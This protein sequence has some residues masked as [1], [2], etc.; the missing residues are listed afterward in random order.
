MGKRVKSCQSVII[1]FESLRNSF[2]Y[3]VLSLLFSYGHVFHC[4][5]SE[6]T[7]VHAAIF[8]VFHEVRVVAEIKLLAMFN[9]KET[10]FLQ[11]IVF[12]DEIRDRGQ[13][14]QRIRRIG[15]NE[16]EQPVT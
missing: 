2:G 11:Q 14:F 1:A 6:D 5:G 13:L 15:K 4:G 8:P 10:V 7:K 3:T 12:N 9:N 16:I